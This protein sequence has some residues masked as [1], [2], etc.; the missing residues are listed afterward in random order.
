MLNDKRHVTNDERLAFG[1]YKAWKRIAM[2]SEGPCRTYKCLVTIAD[3]QESRD[4]V[5]PYTRSLDLRPRQSLLKSAQTQ[6]L[7]LVLYSL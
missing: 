2:W 1:L 7:D 4:L 6:T 5:Q 3:Q